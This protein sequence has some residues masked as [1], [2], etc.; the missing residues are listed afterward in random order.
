MRNS[1]DSSRDHFIWSR[2]AVTTQISYTGLEDKKLGIDVLTLSE[3][4]FMKK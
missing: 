4:R 3:N 1:H 2:I